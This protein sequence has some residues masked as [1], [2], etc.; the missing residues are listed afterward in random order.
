MCLVYNLLF[1]PYI[2]CTF[3]AITLCS[4]RMFHVLQSNVFAQS[5]SDLPLDQIIS[6]FSQI[7]KKIFFLEKLFP[8]LLI[9]K[10]FQF[11]GLVDQTFRTQLM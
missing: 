3:T 6:N 1:K 7:S 4:L 5:G 2:K 9:F 11:L 10:S 8:N